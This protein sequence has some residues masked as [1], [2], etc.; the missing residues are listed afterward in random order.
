MEEPRRE[1]GGALI[2]RVWLDQDAGAAALRG[3]VVVVEA[4][5]SSDPAGVPL[6]GADAILAFVR[7]WLASF[8]DAYA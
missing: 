1:R 5:G 2:V 7:Q 3:R 8:E 4:D 6:A